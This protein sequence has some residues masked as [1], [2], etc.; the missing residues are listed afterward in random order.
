MELP[1]GPKQKVVPMNADCIHF[2]DVEINET[3]CYG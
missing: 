1:E 3:G 2:G